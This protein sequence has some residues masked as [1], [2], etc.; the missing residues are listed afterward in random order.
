MNKI[1]CNHTKVKT[2]PSVLYIGEEDSRMAILADLI[3]DSFLVSRKVAGDNEQC[4]SEKELKPTLRFFN[5]RLGQIR[6]GLS[7]P[8]RPLEFSNEKTSNYLSTI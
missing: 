3:I 7:S 5:G 4:Y 2:N 1:R 6:K 8:G